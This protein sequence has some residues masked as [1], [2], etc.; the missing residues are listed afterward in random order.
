MSGSGFKLIAIRPLK[1]CSPQYRKVL[2]EGE[3]Y[4]FYNDYEFKFD[5]EKKSIAERE[6]VEINYKSLVPSNFYCINND[7]NVNISAIVGKNGSGKSSLFELL[8]LS[9]YLIS[10]EKKIIVTN[11]EWLNKQLEEGKIDE[12]KIREK[13][14]RIKLIYQQLKVEIYFTVDESIYCLK[15]CKG[16]QPNDKEFKSKKINVINL[17]DIINHDFEKLFYTIA[18]NYSIYSLLPDYS[19][20]W[21]VDVFHKNDGYQTPLVINPFREEDGS[22]NIKG[23]IHLAQ[24]RLICNLIDESFTVKEILKDKKVSEIIFEINDIK[25]PLLFNYYSLIEIVD[26]LINRLNV[27][28]DSLFN[29]IYFAILK[30]K[31][32]KV[33]FNKN[34]I[35]HFD[36]ILN[37]TIGKVIKIAHQYKEFEKYKDSDK[38]RANGQ[39][40][41]EFPSI[42]DFDEYLD[43][44]SYN[45]SHIT[46]KLKQI[47]NTVRYNL[48]RN[49]DEFKWEHNRFKIS[50]DGFTYRIKTALNDEKNKVKKVNIIEY[51]PAAFFK[52]RISIYNEKNESG[53]GNFEH[54]S[55]GELQL[56]HTT[57]SI[58]YHILNLNSVKKNDDVTIKYNSINI[59]LD[60]VELYFHPEFQRTFIQ[61]LLRG[62]SNLNISIKNINIIFS[63]HSPFILSDIPKN[64]ILRIDKGDF[65]NFKENE[66]T[67]GGNIHQQLTNSFFMDNTIGEFILSKVEQ[68]IKFYQKV[69]SASEEKYQ[70]LF[71]EYEQKKTSFNYIAENFGEDYI[72]GILK[73]HIAIIEEKLGV[74]ET[75]DKKIKDLELQIE[76]LKSL[77]NDKN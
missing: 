6:V 45:N 44:L 57:Q 63:T 7:L 61:E 67:L 17:D 4:Q 54:L 59:L 31:N 3:V 32:E 10:I 25:I 50:T 41:G 70:T 72:Q 15:I 1:G 20:D 62:L 38:F 51:I 12:N 33:D 71:I 28:R 43:A 66:E 60:E 46:L 40:A 68:I 36:L 49:D 5:D 29:K 65:S 48:L 19:G 42:K 74:S 16:N 2:K 9:L 76:S 56:I 27:T 75:I 23:E 52:P 22:I 18:I 64:N 37:Y 35:P 30:I 73:N 53:N 26:R 34:N 55:S 8:Y 21:L 47:L 11:L 13:E 39:N 24:T 77:K 58:Y 14:N 69:I